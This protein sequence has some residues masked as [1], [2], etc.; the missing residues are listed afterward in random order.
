[1]QDIWSKVIRSFLLVLVISM[2]VAKTKTSFLD[3]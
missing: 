3:F 2:Q 1:M